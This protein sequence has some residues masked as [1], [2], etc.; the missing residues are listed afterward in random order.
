MANF[1]THLNVAVLVS[2]VAATTVASIGLVDVHQTP[3]LFALG[4]LGGL[5]PDIDADNSTPVR[6]AFGLLGLIA[7]FAAVFYALAHY[8]LSIGELCLLAGGTFTLVRYVIFELF[9]R[10]TEHRGVFHSLLAVVFF[11][12]LTTSLS[13]HLAAAPPVLAW[14]HG[15]AVALGYATHL[16]L[17]ELFSVD[18][19]GGRLKRSFGTA[20]KPFGSDLKATLVMGLLTALVGTTLPDPRILPR[21]L[22]RET[23]V[24]PVRQKLWPAQ[25]RWFAQWRMPASR[26]GPGWKLK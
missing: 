23:L 19:L 14:L 1:K 22:S 10:L 16:V 13:Y 18:L 8:R 7:A 6:L 25:G 26:G 9:L 17:D 4:V 24:E 5:L 2:G 20:L 21:L 12:C 11:A 3:V 15:L